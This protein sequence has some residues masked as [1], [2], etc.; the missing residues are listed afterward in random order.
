MDKQ[1]I[2]VVETYDFESK[3]VKYSEKIKGWKIEKFRGDEEIVRAYILAKLVNELGYK[4]ENIEL[5][6]EYDIGRPK[7]NKPRIDIIVKDDDGNAFLYIELKSPQDYEKDKD[8]IIEK[9]LFNLASQEQ[10]QGKKVKYLTLYTFEIVE[11]ETKDKCILIDYEKFSSFDVWKENRDFADELPERYGKAQKEPYAKGEKKDLDTAFSHEQLDGLRKNL[12]NVLWG[13]GGTDDNDV[14]SSLVNIILAKIQDESEKKRGEKYDFQIFSFKDGESFETNEQLFERINE[15]YRRALKQRLNIVDDAK[16]KKSFVIDE[17][18]FSL[19]KLKYTVAELERF[20]FVDGKNSFDG[21]DILGDFF[22]GIIR[23]GFKQSKGQFFTHIN[24]VRFILWGLQL[25]KL[26]INRVNNDLEIP[27]MIDP[28]AGSGTFLI[29]YMK[30]ITDNLKRRFKDKLHETRDV[31]DK[32]NQWF[33]PDHRENKWAKDYIYG[34]EINFNLGTAT[35]VNMILHGD[36]STNIFVKDGLLPFKFYD[37]E[38]APNFLKQYEQDKTYFDKE[39]NAQFDVIITNPPFSVDLDNETKKNVKREFVFGGKKNSENLFV[40]RWYQLLKPNGRFAVVLPESIFDTTENKYIRL[41]VYKYF[42]VKAVVSLPQVTFE[43]FTSTKTSLLFAQKKT[44]AEVEHWDNLWKKYGEEWSFL[45]TRCENLFAVYFDEKDREKLPSIKG[46]TE[47]QEKAI[48]ARMLKDYFED[49]DEKLS[50]KEI[51]LKY[52][53][54]FDTLLYCDNDTKD[55]FG[56]VNTSWVFGEVAKELNY[57]IFMAEADNVGYKRTKRGEKPMPNDLYDIEIAPSELKINEVLYVYEKAIEN[58]E[59]DKKKAQSKE[60]AGRFQEEIDYLKKE[61]ALS[62]KS[63]TKFYKENILKLEFADRTDK[64][65]LGLFDL[66]L[67]KQFRSN[68]VLLRQNAP[69]TVLDYMRQIDW[70]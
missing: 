42:K 57:K 16:L 30:F 13:G 19:N 70:E 33:M 32:Y 49:D 8:E 31:E 15:L 65:L 11:N 58:N 68:N 52:K 41:F 54:E 7:V 20:S 2:K 62:E 69:K 46:M 29:E 59:Q 6:K 45:K 14:F 51:L 22:E 61:K 24:I 25:D 64:E 43:P 17:N 10:G 66:F 1:K 35:K 26:A 44:K 53:N 34:V 28:S 55:V 50:P 37:K 39:V 47:M 27:Y 21:K 5:E 63:L 36:G 9:Q 18:K 12:H 38:T 4:P 23:E 48:L 3:K 56:F 60:I 40:E 67:M